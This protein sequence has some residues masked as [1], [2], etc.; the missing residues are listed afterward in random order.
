MGRTF[1]GP[2]LLLMCRTA[3]PSESG[4]S[5]DPRQ[6]SRRVRVGRK[7]AESLRVSRMFIYK[8]IGII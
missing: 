7:T 4:E 8:A 1:A 2:S 6:I 3:E 5:A